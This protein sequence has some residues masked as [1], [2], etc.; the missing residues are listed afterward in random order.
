MKTKRKAR[1]R[2]ASIAGRQ[3]RI[4]IGDFHSLLEFER[5][6]PD[7]FF[8]PR[9]RRTGGGFL[10]EMEEMVF[11]ANA[12]NAVFYDRTHSPEFKRLIS[13]GHDLAEQAP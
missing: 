5:L 11:Q 4:G 8:K 12:F 13:Q 6:H 9:L 2:F 3:P 7:L 1:K 10:A